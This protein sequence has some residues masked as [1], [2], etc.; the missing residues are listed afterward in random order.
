MSD[1]FE[2]LS[3]LLTDLAK[4][5]NI[6][7]PPFPMTRVGSIVKEGMTWWSEIDAVAS[8]E[9][10]REDVSNYTPDDV[11]ALLDEIRKIWGDDMLSWM[12]A[13]AIARDHSEDEH[14]MRWR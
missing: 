13:N 7:R 2:M 14:D 1:S 12:E 4:N 5:R 6:D 8:F 10:S 11:V 3:G 9:W